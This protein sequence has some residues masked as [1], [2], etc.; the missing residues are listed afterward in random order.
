M[1]SL[2]LKVRV[3]V[4]VG[5]LVGVLVGVRLGI[6]A[7]IRVWS[8]ASGAWRGWWSKSPEKRSGSFMKQPRGGVQ[9]RLCLQGGLGV[10][11]GSGG[12]G[13]E[14]SLRT[15]VQL[16]FGKGQNEGQVKVGQTSGGNL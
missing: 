9:H 11:I 10:I 12:R 6:G 13:G 4:R 7:R 2:H 1:S 15:A 3:R 8:F 5:V 16:P 14:G